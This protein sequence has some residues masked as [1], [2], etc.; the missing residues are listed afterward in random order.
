MFTIT[1]TER[2]VSHCTMETVF[3]LMLSEMEVT[4]LV[5]LWPPTQYIII[6]CTTQQN[7]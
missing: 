3:E 1:N 2:G 5:K 7:K 6:I 4:N